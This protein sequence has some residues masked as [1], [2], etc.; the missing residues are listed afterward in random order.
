MKRLVWIL[1]IVALCALAMGCPAFPEACDYGG[2]LDGGVPD[3]AVTLDAAVLPEAGVD[4]KS[5]R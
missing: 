3:G 5:D 2:C 1:S 4:A